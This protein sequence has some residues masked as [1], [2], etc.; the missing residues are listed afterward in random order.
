MRINYRHT[1]E[2]MQ[3]KSKLN[4]GTPQVKQKYSVTWNP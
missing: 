1:Q 2:I 3:T 4:I